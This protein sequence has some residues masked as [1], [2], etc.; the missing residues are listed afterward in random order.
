[1]EVIRKRII[2]KR[3]GRKGII[4]ERVCGKRM[5]GKWVSGKWVGGEWV[6]GK[7]VGR[8]REVLAHES[9]F[10]P[11]AV[12]VEPVHHRLHTH[13]Q[14]ISQHLNGG[15]ERVRIDGVGL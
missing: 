7:W 11:H 14:L 12:V 6:S 15:V 4:G 5:G 13:F 2:G 1:M 3:V 9:T 10:V 8:R